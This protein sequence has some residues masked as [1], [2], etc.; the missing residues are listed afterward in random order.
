MLTVVYS[1]Y[2]LYFGSK[3]YGDDLPWIYVQGRTF[4][5]GSQNGWMGPGMFYT[6]VHAKKAAYLKQIGKYRIAGKKF[7]TYGELVDTIDHAQTVSAPM[8]SHWEERSLANRTFP[9]AQGAIWTAEDGSLG[10]FLVNYVE[11]DITLDYTIDP[12]KY[13]SRSTSGQYIIKRITPEGS[14]VEGTVKQGIIRR[15]ETLGPLEIRLLQ[16]SGK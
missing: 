15:S 16:I 2:T 6:V 4:L 5:W 8:R 1:G 11:K 12:V 3:A 13:G 10:V 14:S 9:I 7:L